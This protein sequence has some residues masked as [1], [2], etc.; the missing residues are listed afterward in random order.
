M[1]CVRG[2]GFTKKIATFK[3]KM[4]SYVCHFVF[5][6]LQVLKPRQRVTF[7]VVVFKIFT[8]CKTNTT[9]ASH[10]PCF[11]VLSALKP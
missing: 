4:T 2:G 8:T 5:F 6:V 9:N 11:F 1:R 3:I 7:L 10:R